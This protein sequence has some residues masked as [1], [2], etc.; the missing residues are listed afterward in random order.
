MKIACI[1]WGSL[2]WDPRELKIENGWHDDGPM[3]PVEFTRISKD[4][5]VTL[6]IDKCAKPVRTLWALMTCKDLDEAKE[7]LKKREGTDISLIHS[8]IQHKETTDEIEIIVQNWIK[9][10][11]FD[12]A[13]WTGLS[14]SNKAKRRRRPTVEEIITHLTNLDENTKQ[15]AEKY[16][17]MAPKQIDTKYRR[18]IEKKF[19]WTPEEK[20]C[21]LFI[22]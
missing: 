14:Y 18:I 7:S 20:C 12:G 6:I 13:I 2:I 21:D 22:I 8:V 9:L 1:G 19:S 10:K 11:G 16:I 4:G 17:R 15:S 3:L 5:R